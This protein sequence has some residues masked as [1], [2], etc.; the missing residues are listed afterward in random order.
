MLAFQDERFTAIKYQ[1][2]KNSR[3]ILK[4]TRGSFQRRLIKELEIIEKRNNFFLF[5]WIVQIGFNSPKGP[6]CHLQK[7]K[8]GT[9]GPPSRNSSHLRDL[10]MKTNASR[11]GEGKGFFIRIIKWL[12]G[13][14]FKG[15]TAPETRTVT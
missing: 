4:G 15:T 5:D 1:Q 13:F 12:Y 6:S 2:R 14:I 9:H 7:P 3:M 10:M 11:N 8:G